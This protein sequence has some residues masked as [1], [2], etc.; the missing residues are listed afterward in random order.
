MDKKWVSKYFTCDMN[1]LLKSLLNKK[2]SFMR[3]IFPHV[4]VHLG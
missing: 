2:M 1:V 3:G 4:H